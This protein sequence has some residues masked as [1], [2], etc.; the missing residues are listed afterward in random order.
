MCKIKTE[1][2]QD[3]FF[4]TEFHSFLV[5]FTNA[6]VLPSSHGYIFLINLEVKDTGVSFAAVL[7]PL[8]CLKSDTL[9]ADL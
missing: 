2:I 9:S 3:F 1:E 8:L 6:L 4:C 5:F 7:N